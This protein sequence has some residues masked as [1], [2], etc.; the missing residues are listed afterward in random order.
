MNHAEPQYGA[1]L[2]NRRV[3][4]DRLGPWWW[5]G[6]A[7]VC[8]IAATSALPSTNGFT[9]VLPTVAVLLG[10]ALSLFA[11]AQALIHLEVG[12]VY[13]VWSGVG[14]AVIALIGMVALGETATGVKVI[15]LTLIIV[16]VVLINLDEGPSEPT[17][18]ENPS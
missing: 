8:E 1:T 12:V 6:G 14:T 13:A 2:G 9:S 16:G 5:V 7:I 17:P 11:L 15:G 4:G 10:Y 18:S 3:L